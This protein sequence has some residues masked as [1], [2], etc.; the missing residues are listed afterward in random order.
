MNSEGE[1]ELYQRYAEALNDCTVEEKKL[2]NIRRLVEDLKSEIRESDNP[3]FPIELT[4][5]AFKQISERIER[6]AME[7]STIHINVFGQSPQDSILIPSNLRTFVILLMSKA[8]KDGRID[9][10]PS[11]HTSGSEEFHYVIDIDDW[12]STD[13]VLQFTAVVENNVIKTG[14]FNWVQ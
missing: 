12:S 1:K 9:R 2:Y 3:S 7:N 6:L 13:Q 4:A 8:M 5:H 14:F 11:K 10:R